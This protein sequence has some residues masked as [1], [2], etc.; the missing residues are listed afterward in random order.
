MSK[1]VPVSFLM[2]SI[3]GD[4]KVWKFSLL[5]TLGIGSHKLGSHNLYPYPGSLE[6]EYSGN[7]E[8]A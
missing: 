8:I 1:F 2:M 4:Q 6:L 7:S 5:G 3:E